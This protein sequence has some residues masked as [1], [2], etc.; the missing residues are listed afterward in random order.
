MPRVILSFPYIELLRF[1]FARV[2]DK[3]LYRLRNIKLLNS[4]TV[5]LDWGFWA[6]K[7]KAK[8]GFALRRGAHPETHYE[9]YF[10]LN[11]G[12]NIR[13]LAEGGYLDQIS[14][15]VYNLEWARM[16]S[17]INPLLI[18]AAARDDD[19][20]LMR[21]VYERIKQVN[22]TMKIFWMRENILS[23]SLGNALTGVIRW[24][25]VD[26]VKRYIEMCD[27]AKHP[28][29]ICVDEAI[30]KK[31]VAILDYLLS[32]GLLNH[33]CITSIIA[34]DDRSIIDRYIGRLG[35][36]TER[37]RY[38]FHLKMLVLN[39]IQED[40]IIYILETLLKMLPHLKDDLHKSLLSALAS[41]PYRGTSERIT[42]MISPYLNKRNSDNLL[43]SMIKANNKSF[44]EFLLGR[45]T[46]IKQHHLQAALNT[47]QYNLLILLT[48]KMLAQPKCQ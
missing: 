17:C 16:W 48:N 10:T 45:G 35:S 26:G 19:W 30:K 32:L 46:R 39:N 31:D 28:N 5:P 1:V 9:D 37:Q 40:T 34:T 47:K 23:R 27:L 2:N 41:N 25:G 7:F 15:R 4:D 42:P 20:D 43:M 44:I 3:V 6:T 12:N 29:D 14:L 13:Q 24:Q 8:Y 38:N 18:T 33:S 11:S 36:L 21:R 22:E